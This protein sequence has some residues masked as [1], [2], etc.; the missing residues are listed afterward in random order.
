MSTKHTPE[1]WSNA[2]LAKGNIIISE[3]DWERAVECVNALQDVE[4]PLEWRKIQIERIKEITELRQKFNLLLA[5]AERFQ[6]E[7]VV[8][9]NPMES[10]N[11]YAIEMQ[12]NEA[13]MVAK[14]GTNG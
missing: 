1:P 13:I 3:V 12:I 4:R 6:K 2:P 5:A 14:G 7:W 8:K 11:N 9:G 10:A